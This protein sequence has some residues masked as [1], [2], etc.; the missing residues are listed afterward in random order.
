MKVFSSWKAG[1]LAL[2]W[3]ASGAFLLS[4]A[5]WEA[6]GGAWKEEE[7]ILR[8]GKV[9]RKIAA[10]AREGG[11][12]ADFR[13]GVEIRIEGGRTWRSA[14][15]F[16]RGKDARNLQH[17]YLSSPAGGRPS[18]LQY[19]RVEK[20]KESYPFPLGAAFLPVEA[21]RWY[22]LEVL[23]RGK[24][25]NV[26]L[27]GRPWLAFTDLAPGGGRAVGLLAFDCK[28]SF[29]RFHVEPLPGD[30]KLFDVVPLLGPLGG[31]VAPAARPLEE[32]IRL[33]ASFAKKDAG[34]GKYLKDEK[35][36]PLPPYVC[37]A[38][39]LPGDDLSYDA[40]YPAF[41]HGLFIDWFLRYYRWSGDEDF[42]RRAEDLADWNLSHSTPRDWP[43]G[44]LPWSTWKA[45]K[46][47]G[48][49]DGE[50]LEPDKA[51][52]LGKS[53]LALYET[54]KKEKYRIGAERIAE[55]LRKR[56]LPGGNWYFR[57]NP[58]TGKPVEV[59]TADVIYPVLLF[60]ELGRVLQT[61]RFEKAKKKALAWLMEN[62]LRSGDWSGFYEDVA[63]G[64]RSQGNWV[65][66]EAIRYFL[67]RRGEDPR[68]L[69]AALK[70]EKWIEARF[71]AYWKDRGPALYE[72]TACYVPMNCHTSHWAL[73]LADL[74]EA[75]GKKI[76][77]KAASSALNTVTWNLGPDGR[78][79]NVDVFDRGTWRSCWYSLAF[80]QFGLLLE[81]LQE[82]PD[83]KRKAARAGKKAGKR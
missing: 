58:R 7:G 2:V 80:S 61:G 78:C 28:A 6:W 43:Y 4:H 40:S 3:G 53:Y 1:F 10:L 79:P 68:Y 32:V 71:V 57:V 39:L 21:G 30:A 46:P 27:D 42:L 38:V 48:G 9:E 77:K 19:C 29:R 55:T 35:G 52:V 37:H 60:Q 83:L 51:A 65:P 56:Q 72:Q 14:G 23:A 15:L 69:P 17:V 13:A 22:R 66:L 67:A 75:T 11:G 76:Y 70:I 33:A 50:S 64:A 49:A 25:L 18:K 20:G 12:P 47:G 16:F 74:Y 62:P 31:K 24:R 41:H 45:G 82:H 81:F 73:A 8:Q 63:A 44:S 54:T 34:K 36:R 26:F 5:G 59:Y